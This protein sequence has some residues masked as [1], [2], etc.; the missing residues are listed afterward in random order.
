MPLPF[1]PLDPARPEMGPSLSLSGTRTMKAPFVFLPG[2]T[3]KEEH[4]PSGEPGAAE[5]RPGLCCPSLRAGHSIY[6]HHTHQVSQVRLLTP[7]ERPV[8]AH[9]CHPLV[10]CLIEVYTYVI[11]QVVPGD[12]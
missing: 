9:G 6:H 1:R 12:R 3:H 4:S 7:H 8:R 10:G 2:D 11:L 5:G